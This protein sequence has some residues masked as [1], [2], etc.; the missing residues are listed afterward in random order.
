MDNVAY[1]GQAKDLIQEILERFYVRW[2]IYS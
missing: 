1:Y 2:G